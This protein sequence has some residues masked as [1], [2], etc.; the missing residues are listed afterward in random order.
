[1]TDSRTGWAPVVHGRTFR[2]DFRPHL[3]VVP[4]WFTDQDIATVRRFVLAS[5]RTA[6]RLPEGERWLM[7]KTSQ[8]QMV[9]VTCMAEAVSADMIHDR[10]AS[11]GAGRPLHVFLGF[12]TGDLAADPPPME[13]EI[14]KPLYDFVRSRWD[15]D[16]HD[17]QAQECEAVPAKDE[18]F[19]AP[20]AD[21]RVEGLTLE[22]D[23][24]GS[25]KPVLRVWP[26]SERAALWAAAARHPGRVSLCIGMA[27]SRDAENSP[28][29]NIT[30]AGS[31][32][33]ATLDR[34][35]ELAAPTSGR[36]DTVV[37]D[38]AREDAS[39]VPPRPRRRFVP[40]DLWHRI[41]RAIDAI[42]RLLGLRGGQPLKALPAPPDG[43]DDIF[44]P[45]SPTTGP[46]KPD[47]FDI[48]DGPSVAVGKASPPPPTQKPIDE[49]PPSQEP[50]DE[51]P[52]SQEPS[53]Q[54]PPSQKLSNVELHDLITRRNLGQ[55]DAG[56][57]P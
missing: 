17:P 39:P 42:L 18:Q 57:C 36:Q 43:F 13:L 50:S 6:E 30:V 54:A 47:V 31:N 56:T 11:G 19:P 41:F 48:Y 29:G 45:V 12:A 35:P 37:R 7:V 33:P 49:P 38:H 14:Y 2:V 3:L 40:A 10:S 34:E 25:Q 24:H 51:T 53:D 5:M 32:E 44:Q 52:P 21:R 1:V 4:E 9:G 23:S 16:P 22:P 28:L 46:P 20:P 27:N 15:E 26:D 55:K 8:F